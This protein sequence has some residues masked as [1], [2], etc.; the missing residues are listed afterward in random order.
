MPY[1]EF[2]TNLGTRDADSLGLDYTKCT[3]GE[4]LLV[5]DEVAEKVCSA[6]TLAQKTHGGSF[7]KRVGIKKADLEKL[8]APEK[9]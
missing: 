4:T 5:S 3:K 6:L 2:T 7:A 1:V 8:T 9:K